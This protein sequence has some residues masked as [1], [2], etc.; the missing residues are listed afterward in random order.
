MFG[1]DPTDL[2]SEIAKGFLEAL[3]AVD[4]AEWALCARL[5]RAAHKAGTRLVYAEAAFDGARWA[6]YH[7]RAPVPPWGHPDFLMLGT[8]DLLLLPYGTALGVYSLWILLREDAKRMFE[9]HD[10]P[11]IGTV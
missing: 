9:P 6:E 1:G 8:V 2:E 5:V 4:P 10:S 7:S 3:Y 11:V